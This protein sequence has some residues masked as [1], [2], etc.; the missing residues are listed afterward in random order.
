M[1]EQGLQEGVNAVVAEAKSGDACA[2]AGEDRGGEVGECLGAADRVV[3][4]G[5]DAEQAPVGGEAELP[6]VGQAGQPFGYAEVVRC[7]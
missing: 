5:L 2:F 1:D 3:A 7:R 6:Q 4:D